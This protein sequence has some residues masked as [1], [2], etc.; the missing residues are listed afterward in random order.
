M[1]NLL[2]AG[3]TG[4]GKSVCMNT[5]L[6]ALLFQ[7]APHELKFILIDPKRVELMPYDGIPHLLTPVITEAE[8]ALQALRWAVAEMGRRLHRFSEQGV[9][10]LDEYNDK[11][12]EEEKM[13]PRIVVVIDELAD[14]M[15]R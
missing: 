10:N 4:S 12:T 1:P 13:L 3:A 7:N 11:Q 2:I 15:M 8:K 5:F 14:L 6:T 9:R